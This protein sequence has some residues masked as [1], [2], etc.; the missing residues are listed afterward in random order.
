MAGVCKPANEKN[1]LQTFFLVCTGLLVVTFAYF[2]IYSNF[3]K[4]VSKDSRLVKFVFFP[5]VCDLIQHE[6]SHLSNE[7]KC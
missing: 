5:R 6:E 4:Q 3:R 1:I 7:M 2:P